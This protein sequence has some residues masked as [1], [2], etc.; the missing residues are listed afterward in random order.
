MFVLYVPV[1]CV[2]YELH[3]EAVV[4]CVTS[5]QEILL[6]KSQLCRFFNVKCTCSLPVDGLLFFYILKTGF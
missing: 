4:S 6:F 3:S 1:N 5:K 2:F